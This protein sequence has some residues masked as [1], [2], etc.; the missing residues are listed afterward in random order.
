MKNNTDILNDR[1]KSFN[2]H[3]GPRVG[4][5][6]Y[7]PQTDERI[8]Q[9]TRFTHH[10]GDRI[11]TGGTQNHGGYYLDRNG[12]F[13]YSGGLD[14]GIATADLIDTG[15]TRPGSLWF[16]DG[17]VAGAGR[18]VHFMADMRVYT[19]REGADLNGLWHITCPYHLVAT[20]EE[21]GCGYWF[22]VTE[23]GVS[24]IAFRTKEELL[25]W[26]KS[27]RLEL[28]QDVTKGEFCSQHLMYA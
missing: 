17:N 27:K 11:Q 16:F 6:L 28:A 7:I 25:S 1:I 10:W 12:F 8:P 23:R 13:S 21:V 15:E 3:V 5:Y 20:K 19:V 26:L 24:H 22:T 2:N 14:S 4:D 9:Y 18:G